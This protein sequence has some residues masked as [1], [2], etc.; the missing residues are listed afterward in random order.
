MSKEL[1]TRNR[2]RRWTNALLIAATIFALASV[3][4]HWLRRSFIARVQTELVAEGSLMPTVPN[5]HLGERELLLLFL[6]SDCRFC[7][8]SAPFYHELLQASREQDVPLRIYAITSDGT[9]KFSS[10]MQRESLIFDRVILEAPP[11]AGFPVV[12][13]IAVVSPDGR[14][15]RRWVGQLTLDEEREVLTT[16]GLSRQPTRHTVGRGDQFSSVER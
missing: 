7:Q 16:L 3:S 8:A 15:E 10:F 12:P 13:I 9:T 5:L 1:T 11:I 14:V 4:L 2:M 6:S